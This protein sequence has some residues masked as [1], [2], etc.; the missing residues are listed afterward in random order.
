MA[1]T[2]A[3]EPIDTD[4]LVAA[5]SAARLGIGVG[6]LPTLPAGEIVDGEHRYI[7]RELSTLDYYS[8]V[9]A[10]AEDTSA[11]LLERAK[12]LAI[13]NSLWDE[14]F[15]IRV[16]GLKDQLAAGLSG[17]VPAGLTPGVQLK[18]IRSEVEV[19]LER[20]VRT[21]IDGLFP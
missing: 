8:R 19:L 17:T 16:A 21:F 20:R 12:F 18:I 10:L 15:E 7:N 6:V 9:L 1:T 14:F 4:D 3:E 11:P 2:Q 13:F 5:A